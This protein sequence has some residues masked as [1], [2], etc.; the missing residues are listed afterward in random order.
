MLGSELGKGWPGDENASGQ[1]KPGGGMCALQL[2]Q[3]KLLSVAKGTPLAGGQ[4]RPE[5]PQALSTQPLLAIRLR[6]EASAPSIPTPRA[7]LSCSA[8]SKARPR[9]SISVGLAGFPHGVAP[10]LRGAPGA[11]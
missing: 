8:D 11:H 2:H 9:A 7:L 3:E 4:W 6:L 1:L 10:W 5:W